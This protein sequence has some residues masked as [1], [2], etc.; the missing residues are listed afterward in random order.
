MPFGSGDGVVMVGCGTAVI[1]IGNSFVTTAAFGT[2]ESWSLN[3]G[4]VV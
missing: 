2:A 1:D 3:V 4:V